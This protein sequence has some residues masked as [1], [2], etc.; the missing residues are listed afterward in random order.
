MVSIWVGLAA[1]KL[2]VHL[3]TSGRYGFHQDELYY[4][5]AGHHPQLGYVDFPPMTPMLARLGEALFGATPFGL[6]VLPALAGAALVLLA[7]LIARELGGQR[8][9][10]LL[11]ALAA[12]ASPLLLATNWLL[13]TVT[14]DQLA[15][16]VC[17][18][19]II[20]LLRTGESRLWPLIG[21]AFG[22]GLETKYTILALGAGLFV[23]LVATRQRRLLRSGGVW[24]AG[25][26]A[27]LL[28]LPNLTWQV[29]NDWPSWEY[30]R[31]HGG[32]ISASAGVLAFLVEQIPYA[33]IIVLPL[34]V[35]GWW[36]LWREPWVRPVAIGVSF[37]FV[38]LMVTGKSYYVG[39]LYPL[40]LA[41]G[42]VRVEQLLERRATDPRRWQRVIAGIVA[43]TGLLVS[44]LLIPVVPEEVMARSPLVNLRKDFADSV[45][46]PEVAAQIAAVA[47]TTP[48]ATIL[49]QTYAE[50]GAVDLFG[51]RYGLP[52][53]ISG[54]LTY[55]FWKPA[56]VQDS[57][58]I[59]VG[60]SESF[61]RTL[62]RDVRPSG[63]L[64]NSL[65]V[66]NEAFGR[67]IAVCRD[68]ITPLDQ[69][70]P[71]LKNFQ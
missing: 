45:G 1:V 17:L 4:L 52:S 9:A 21:L 67:P 29:S 53:A 42:A 25:G 10:Q 31:L 23:G 8:Y 34:W 33:G 44:P 7:G 20:R 71:R 38:A 12:L 35:A 15:W 60:F 69:V 59:A 47:G 26:I 61:L 11:A 27:L 37:T 65:G 64:T 36:Q 24:L 39:G 14:F 2:A 68:P 41:A 50:A 48:G 28:L 18:L 57:T 19:L 32:Q 55:Y 49:T 40:L 16:T 13:Q 62:F 43:V 30:I 63:T 66:H 58:V 6:R 46:W 22:L 51:G 70:W 5:A 54:H 56:H 3:A